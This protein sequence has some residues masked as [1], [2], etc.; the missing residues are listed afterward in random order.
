MVGGAVGFGVGVLGF[1]FFE[2]GAQFGLGAEESDSLAAVAHAGFEDPPFSIRGVFVL[3]AGEALV[4]LVG[5][6]EG[7]I[8]EFGVVE[9]EIDCWFDMVLQDT[10]GMLGEPGRD[11]M[12][13]VVL[14]D[15]SFADDVRVGE[16]G[17]GMGEQVVKVKRFI[18]DDLQDGA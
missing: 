8:E 12:C 3:V 7:F 6:E 17:R 11:S 18:G 1:P 4:E 2:D 16:G 9:F 13:E 5:F 14:P 15:Q 10:F